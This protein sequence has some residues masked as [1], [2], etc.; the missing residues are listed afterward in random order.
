MLYALGRIYVQI[1]VLITLFLWLSLTIK[2]CLN[3]TLE[4]ENSAGN[5]SIIA[6]ES[7]ETKCEAGSSQ[8][9]LVTL[10]AGRY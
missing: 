4:G 3:C 10:Q 9:V 2:L 7:E 5:F 8:S 6:Q 1:H